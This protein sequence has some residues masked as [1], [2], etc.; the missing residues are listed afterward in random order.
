MSKRQVRV[1]FRV[2]YTGTAVI[3]TDDHEDA[4]NAAHSVEFEDVEKKYGRDAAEKMRFE[5]V[6]AEVFDE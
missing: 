5:W 2:T 1:T 3:D 6:D 4:F